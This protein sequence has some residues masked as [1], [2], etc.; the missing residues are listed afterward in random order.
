MLEWDPSAMEPMGLRVDGMRTLDDFTL[1]R[2]WN[3][4]TCQHTALHC[5]KSHHLERQREKKRFEWNSWLLLPSLSLSFLRSLPDQIVCPSLCVPSHYASKQA[6]SVS[7]DPNGNSTMFGMPP[8]FEQTVIQS[9]VPILTDP[10]IK[11][12]K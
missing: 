10:Y 3:A 2:V 8:T 7:S 6:S 12:A 9:R 11:I 5:D 4:C 1:E